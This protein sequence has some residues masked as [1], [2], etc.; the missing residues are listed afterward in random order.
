MKKLIIILLMIII[1]PTAYAAC[2]IN[3]NARNTNDLFNQISSINSQFQSCPYKLSRTANLL[4]GG[5]TVVDIAMNNGKTQSLT[6]IISNGKVIGF[7]GGSGDCTQRIS[8]SENDLNSILSSDDAKVVAS[9]VAQKRI[10]I[11]GCTFASKV[12]LFFANPIARLIAR[13]S[14]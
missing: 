6:I 9:L 3:I 5:N 14:S 7:Q 4:V 1:L 12:K 10:K 13:R 8:I 2:Q 11:T